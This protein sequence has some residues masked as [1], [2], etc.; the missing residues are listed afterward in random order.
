MYALLIILLCNFKLF[1]TLGTT[2]GNHREL[3]NKLSI[4]TESLGEHVF[5]APHHGYVPAGQRA[6]VTP[7]T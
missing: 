4:N 1:S 6:A 7:V 5:A 3:S 2:G